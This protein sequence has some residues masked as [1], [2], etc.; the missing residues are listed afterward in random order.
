MDQ[1]M[2][3]IIANV[4]FISVIATIFTFLA[5]LAQAFFAGKLFCVSKKQA[6]ILNSQEFNERLMLLITLRK[7]REDRSA[8][9]E[10]VRTKKLEPLVYLG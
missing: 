3:W 5:I 7:E 6:M 8:E 10:G 2:Q 4:A 1:I 9:L